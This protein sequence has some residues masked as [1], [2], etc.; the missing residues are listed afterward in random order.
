MT[1]VSSSRAYT[2]VSW[3]ST[4]PRYRA[5]WLGASCL[6]E[7]EVGSRTKPWHPNVLSDEPCVVVPLVRKFGDL[8]FGGLGSELLI[9]SQWFH[10][11]GKMLWWSLAVAIVHA[12]ALV[13]TLIAASASP[14]VEGLYG[15]A[16]SMRMPL[17]LQKSCMS[18]LMNA[19]ALSG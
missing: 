8:K 4:L 2:L 13:S 9:A 1:L 19:L 16:G 11:K 3:L 18:W 14:L 17:D 15:T 10:A 7:V 12:A 5:G 6:A